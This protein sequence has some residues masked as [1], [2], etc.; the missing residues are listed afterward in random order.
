MLTCWQVCLPVNAFLIEL[1]YGVRTTIQDIARAVGVTKTTVSLVLNKKDTTSRISQ[2][3]RSKVLKTA[4]EL[5]YQPSFA[6]RTLAIG[7]TFTLGFFCPVIS[8]PFYSGLAAMTMIEAEKRGYHL[9]IATTEAN[10][11]KERACLERLIKERRVDGIVA[12][13]YALQPG[14]GGYDRILNSKFPLVFE[15][16]TKGFPCV[17]SN[18]NGG[19]EEAIAYLKDKGHGRVGFVDQWD[20]EVGN[21]KVEAFL[22][23][24]SKYDIR[25]VDH[26][27]ISYSLEEA[28][29]LGRRIAGK[30]DRPSA[31]IVFSDHYATGVIDGLVDGG[32]RVPED[33]AV[34][35]IDGTE[36]GA[37]FRPALTTIAQDY[38][39]LVASAVDLL[40]DAI[41]NGATKAVEIDIPTKLVI[42]ASA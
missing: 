41:E 19:M 32:V 21:G 33:V 34:I 20:V 26:E 1:G 23:A 5:N 24:C 8:A 39:R 27:S 2:A 4:R 14:S 17:N 3:T 28:V 15:V 30:P 12:W 42:R 40:L 31:L 22:A 18:W 38:H 10:L 16:A 9:V 25:K 11:A 7:R 13:S 29:Q 36:L 35:G 6:A 37:Y